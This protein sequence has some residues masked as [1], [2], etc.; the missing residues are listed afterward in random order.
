[1]M[2]DLEIAKLENARLLAENIDLRSHYV[3]ISVVADM[4]SALKDAKKQLD[5]FSDFIREAGQ[6]DHYAAWMHAREE[7][8]HAGMGR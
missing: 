7:E 3:H 4:I 8:P 1:M 2:S 5:C 6:S